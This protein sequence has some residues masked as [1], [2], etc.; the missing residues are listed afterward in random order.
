MHRLGSLMLK[1]IM[2]LAKFGP[3]GPYFARG[4]TGGRPD[5]RRQSA[6]D[7]PCAT[8]TEIA[9]GDLAPS[10]GPIPGRGSFARGRSRPNLIGQFLSFLSSLYRRLQVR[11]ICFLV[12]VF[13]IVNAGS[14]N[15]LIIRCSR[16]NHF[17]NE[18]QIQNIMRHVPK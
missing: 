7:S 6:K 15:D 18:I 14:I 11:I 3:P 10:C 5:W 9:F 4:A 13:R 16:A 17:L 1:G 2:G 12:E 8:H